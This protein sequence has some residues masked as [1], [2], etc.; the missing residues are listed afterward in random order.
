M[1]D[2]FVESLKGI[3]AWALGIVGSLFV[4]GILYLLGK[5]GASVRRGIKTRRMLQQIKKRA[6]TDGLILSKEWHQVNRKAWAQILFPVLGWGSFYITCV[7]ILPPILSLVSLILLVPPILGFFGII[8]VP[9]NDP[10]DY[11]P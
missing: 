11:V 2:G 3:L 4:I 5:T 6:D 7:F 8:F 9:S 1:M 10:D